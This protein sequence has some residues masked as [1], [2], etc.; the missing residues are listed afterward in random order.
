MMHLDGDYSDI[1]IILAFFVL[2][3]GAMWCIM[4]DMGGGK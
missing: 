1:G 3:F 2:F 4:K